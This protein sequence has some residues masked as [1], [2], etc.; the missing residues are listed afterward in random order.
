MLTDGVSITPRPSPISSSPGA[1]AHG[2]DDTAPTRPSKSPT[3]AAVP[4][5]PAAISVFWRNLLASRSAASEE[6]RTPSVAAVKITPVLIALKWRSVWRN[7]ETTNDTSISRSHWRFWVTMPTFEVRFLNSSTESNASLPALSRELMNRK[8]PARNASPIA[9]NTISSVTLVSACKIPK[10]RQNM[11]TPDRIAPTASNARVESGGT[12]STTRRPR[13][14]IV[15][16]TRAWNTNAARQLIPDVMTPPMSGPAAAPMPPNPLI[17]PNAFARDSIEVNAIVVR[18][19]TGGIRN[20][21]PTP[22]N[23]ELPRMRIP[24]PGA[25]ALKTVPIPYS[26]RPPRKHRFRPQRSVNLLQ[27]IMRTAMITRNSVM[28]VCTPF[29]SVCR[30]WLMSLIITFMFDPAKLQMNCASASGAMNARAEPTQLAVAN[31]VCLGVALT[32]R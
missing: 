30:S 1:N 13:K 17:T 9:T 6:T 8:K 16:T 29:T 2:L 11:P 20:A 18:M 28:Q 23:T 4:A 31:P 10:T 3:P 15:T 24:S 21:V 12:G 5:N 7:T 19:Y 32:L 25:I 22:W 26:I 14:M 27:G